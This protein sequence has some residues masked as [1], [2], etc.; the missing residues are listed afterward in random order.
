HA[1]QRGGFA[2]AD[3]SFGVFAHSHRCYHIPAGFKELLLP[4]SDPASFLYIPGHITLQRLPKRPV[5]YTV[6]QLHPG[7]DERLIHDRK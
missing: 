5:G 7:A 2:D 3:Q 6:G 1:H 4:L